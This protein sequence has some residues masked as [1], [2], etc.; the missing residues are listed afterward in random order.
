LALPFWPY[1]WW[2]SFHSGQ[3]G[4]VSSSISV[5]LELVWKGSQSVPLYPANE[6][7]HLQDVHLLIWRSIFLLP[8]LGGLQ[9]WT[10]IVISASTWRKIL[11]CWVILSVGKVFFF[12]PF[13]ELFHQVF[14]LKVTTPSTQ[15]LD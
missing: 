12:L 3:L 9:T 10:S 8:I 14:F 13:F 15:T 2:F 5:A 4:E 11:L 7:A 6:A 1:F